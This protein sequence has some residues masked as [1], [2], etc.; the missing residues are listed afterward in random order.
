[1]HFATIQDTG[2]SKQRACTPCSGLFVIR[3]RE[4]VFEVAASCSIS[5]QQENAKLCAN[6]FLRRRAAAALGLAFARLGNGSGLWFQ[7]LKQP[8]AKTTRA[9]CCIFVISTSGDPCLEELKL[10]WLRL[11]NFWVPPKTRFQSSTKSLPAPAS[12]RP[13]LLPG[14]VRNRAC[15]N[16]G[17][18]PQLLWLVLCLCV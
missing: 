8:Q 7:H 9:M 18:F 10:T 1:M 14:P 4:I 17:T 12:S 15:C 13:F 2:W 11:F 16:A 5:R 3:P 6:I